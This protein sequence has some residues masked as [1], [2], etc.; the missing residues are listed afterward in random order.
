VV[1]VGRGHEQDEKSSL[2]NG[3]DDRDTIPTSQ[4][5]ARPKRGG[6]LTSDDDRITDPKGDLLDQV[7][8]QMAPTLEPSHGAETWRSPR[9]EV[10]RPQPSSLA[11][12]ERTVAAQKQSGERNTGTALLRVAAIFAICAGAVWLRAQFGDRSQRATATVG[13]SEVQQLAP[14]AVVAAPV[15]PV[16]PPQLAPVE[17][18]PAAPV[19]AAPAA[20]DVAAPHAAAPDEAKVVPSASGGAA[21]PALGGAR[22][23]PKRTRHTSIDISHLPDEPSRQDVIE[24][25]NQLRAELSECS[26]GRSGTAEID[27]TI[28]GSGAVTYALI[29]GDY[30]GTPQGSCIARTIRR[31]HFEPFKKPRV[32]ILYRMAL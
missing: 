21:R 2:A 9:P 1:R 16:A 8:S 14:R 31:A 5:K 20:P 17:P 11:P 6:E 30:A 13:D 22:P 18:A 23:A 27:L 32:R 15:A 10:K 3:D 29:E 12:R 7:M 24:G 19:T 26:K 28:A 25:L 4:S